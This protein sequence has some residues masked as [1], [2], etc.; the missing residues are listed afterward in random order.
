MKES[1]QVLT[2]ALTKIEQA[3][4]QICQVFRCNKDNGKSEYL[5]GAW[6]IT[7]PLLEVRKALG[8]A[9]V[10]KRTFF[11]VDGYSLM[12]GTLSVILSLLAMTEWP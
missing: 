1:E 2:E 3:E 10:I 7:G 5:D 6:E 4:L 9:N 11:V 12:E 8:R